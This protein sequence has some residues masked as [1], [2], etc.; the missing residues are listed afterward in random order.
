MSREEIEIIILDELNFLISFE[1][2]T[3]Q[4]DEALIAALELVRK[5]YL[6]IKLD[7]V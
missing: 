2:Q 5:E 7:N 6:P 3:E 4:P 1:K